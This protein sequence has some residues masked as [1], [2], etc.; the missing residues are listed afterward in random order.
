MRMT[1][2]AP[3]RTAA[4]PPSAHLTARIA[5]GDPD[6]FGAF[7]EAWFER[8]FALARSIT[9]RDEA[10]CLDVVQDCMLRV[11]RSMRPLADERAVQA[12]MAKT[13]LSTAL[14][15]L[16]SERRR[17][18]REETATQRTAA[19]TP[20]AH[21]EA[22][23]AEQTAWLRERLAELSAEERELLWQRFAGDATLQAA[24]AALGISGNAAHGRIR[25][26]LER[27]RAAAKGVFGD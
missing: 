13:V 15:G 6:A 2:P 27:L 11:V 8:A 7:Y 24:G 5:R 1:R 9:R 16:R 18:Q 14:D 22:E 25:R 20:D 19:A 21:A 17:A 4:A 10:F 26:I 23:A 12:W 3:M